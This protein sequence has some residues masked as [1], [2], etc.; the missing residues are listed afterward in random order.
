MAD[1]EKNPTLILIRGI[2]GSGK[3][4]IAKQ[5]VREI[6]EKMCVL[7]DPDATDYDSQQYK[8][9]SARIG[10]EGVDH[11]LHPYRFLRE[12]AYVGIKE[13]KYIVWNQAF[14][15][16]EVFHKM[17]DGMQAYAAAHGRK[18]SVLVVE[19]PIDTVTAQQRIASRVLGGGHDV[20]ADR[21]ITFAA[22]YKSFDDDNF[23]IVKVNGTE[24]AAESVASILSA[25]DSI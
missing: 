13:G 19:V 22:N 18:L 5:L 7:L 23:T 21:F 3:S 25:I 15:N 12:Q 17:V 14:T 16:R 20:P 11:K 10:T 6:G 9:Y 24:P 2:P 1:T 8:N 4:Y